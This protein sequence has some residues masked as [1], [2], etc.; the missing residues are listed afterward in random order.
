MVSARPSQGVPAMKRF[1]ICFRVEQTFTASIE[2]EAA[3]GEDAR[4][5]AS[6][7]GL[8]KP[9]GSPQNWISWKAKTP[10]PGS[11]PSTI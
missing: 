10:S 9:R 2:V 3:S 5:G 6:T 4:N 1:L 7:A 11:T 8:M